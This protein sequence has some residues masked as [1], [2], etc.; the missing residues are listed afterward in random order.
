MFT[1]II[2]HSGTIAELTTTSAGGRI[3]V[4]APE[5]AA[6]LT[7]SASI[8]VSGCCLTVVH[9]D[10]E[11]FSADLS[12]ETLRKTS[13]ASLRP[14]VF[15]NLEQPLTAG[16][17]FGGHFVLGHV[18]GIGRVAHLTRDGDSWLLGVEI[19]HDL[20]R[21]IVSKGSITIDGVS[22]TIARWQ[23]R[24]AEIAVIPYTYQHTNIHHRVLGD[25][26]NLE[27]DILGKYIERY[28]TQRQSSIE[29][30]PL[31]LTD[32]ISQGF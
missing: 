6:K 1:G 4:R 29:A 8:A 16:K 30:V 12:Q 2:E 32:L 13:F 23:N 3:T 26:V 10:A 21:Y 17:E 20:A 28:L 27:T 9:R 19:P 15:V 7:I 22:L 11:T 5:I 25:P 31:R 14:G 18:D 24:I